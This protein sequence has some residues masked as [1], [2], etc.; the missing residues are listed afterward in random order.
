V[1]AVK[2]AEFL[3]NWVDKLGLICEPQNKIGFLGSSY[4]LGII[5][6]MLFVPALSD[7]YGRKKIFC[8]TMMVSLIGQYGLITSDSL[9]KSTLYM[10]LVGM[11]WP[12]KRV[13]G[14][15]YILE[16]LPEHLQK[17]YITVFTLFDYPSI[18]F[19]SLYYQYVNPDWYPMQALGVVLSAICLAYCLVLMPESP[20][21]RYLRQD[22]ESVRDT[23][24]WI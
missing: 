22:F 2:D 17:Q 15:N 1:R 21:F 20:K 9:Y 18:L 3:I 14:L 16:F 23:V 6:S 5:T 4:F 7:T 24:A 13:T 10:I 12:G 8:I 19:I 11:T